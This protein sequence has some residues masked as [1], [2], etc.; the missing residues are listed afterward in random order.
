MENGES[1]EEA[2]FSE[3]GER[4]IVVTKKRVVK[5]YAIESLDLLALYD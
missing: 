2:L 3:D 1:L 5:E 4:L